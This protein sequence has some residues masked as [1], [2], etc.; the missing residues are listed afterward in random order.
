MT[1]QTHGWHSMQG[2]C[3]VC[4]QQFQQQHSFQGHQQFRP[5]QIVPSQSYAVSRWKWAIRKYAEGYLNNGNEYW[6]ETNRFYTDEEVAKDFPEDKAK[7]Y[8]T[9]IKCP[10]KKQEAKQM[11]Q[12]E[13]K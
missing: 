3:P 1:C 13:K 4:F 7:L 10:P 5:H 6:T 12:G 9:E 8:W 11:Q 2:Q